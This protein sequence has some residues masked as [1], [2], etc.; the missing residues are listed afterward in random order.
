MW[1][2]SYGGHLLMDVVVAMTNYVIVGIC[3]SGANPVI[4][5]TSVVLLNV[6]AQHKHAAIYLYTQ[7]WFR[8]TW[9]PLKQRFFAELPECL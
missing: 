6:H 2:S 7:L 8:Q 9:F 3:Y 4:I 5:S 1:P